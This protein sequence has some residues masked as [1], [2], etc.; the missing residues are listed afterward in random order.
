MSKE[1]R[2][3]KGHYAVWRYDLYPY[4]MCAKIVTAK[5]REY[6][7]P[8]SPEW[9]VMV[10]G[11]GGNWFVCRI[12]LPPATGKRIQELRSTLRQMMHVQKDELY[13][14][15]NE[16]LVSQ[17]EINADDRGLAIVDRIL[18]PGVRAPDKE[19]EQ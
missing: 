5:K 7:D 9:Q 4:F 19:D 8:D 15:M 18:P 6:R 1:P 14:R 17:L 12:C 3:R 16:L 10:E 2:P 11:F 13:S